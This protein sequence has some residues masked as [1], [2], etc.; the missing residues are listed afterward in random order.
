MLVTIHTCKKA[1][2]SNVVC[3]QNIKTY[4]HESYGYHCYCCCCC[5]LGD[6]CGTEGDG[7]RSEVHGDSSGDSGGGYD[8]DGARC[9]VLNDDC[10]R[11]ISSC[12]SKILNLLIATNITYFEP[13]IDDRKTLSIH[14]KS[15]FFKNL[16]RY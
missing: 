3:A 14:L 1:Y 9:D 8:S 6:C 16:A 13:N 4:L 5:D 10:W 7:W 2:K 15:S 12:L 11:K